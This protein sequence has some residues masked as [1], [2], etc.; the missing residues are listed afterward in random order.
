M[1]TILKK[2]S[3]PSIICKLLCF[4]SKHVQQFIYKELWFYYCMLQHSLIVPSFC[5]FFFFVFTWV[6]FFFICLVLNYNYH[7][8]HCL[9][10]TYI[11]LD[12]IINIYFVFFCFFLLQ[13]ISIQ[14]RI[15]RCIFTHQPQL[16]NVEELKKKIYV[17]TCKG[18]INRY[19][20]KGLK[21]LFK[22][23]YNF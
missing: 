18:I 17:D 2:F 21:N 16:T 7:V 11:P 20:G 8:E 19:F 10:C 23:F 5:F 13:K 12:E 22:R 1:V 6:W 9:N 14:N 3:I 4:I 15:L